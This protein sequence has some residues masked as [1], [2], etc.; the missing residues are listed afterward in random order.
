MRLATLVISVHSN[1][2]AIGLPQI[3]ISGPDRFSFGPIFHHGQE[4]DF[5]GFSNLCI[6]YKPDAQANV[7]VNLVIVETE[8]KQGSRGIPQ[9]LSY[10]GKLFQLICFSAYADYLIGMIR[11]QRRKY[12]MAPLVIFGLSTDY[13]QFHLLRINGDGQVGYCFLSM[14]IY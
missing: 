2:P 6:C 13:E 11:T 5:R 7:A 4:H 12:G 8:K 14:H 10:M 3:S 9:V 1:P